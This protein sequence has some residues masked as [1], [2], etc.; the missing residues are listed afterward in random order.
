[1][2]Q[3]NKRIT[4]SFIFLSLLLIGVVYA[5]LQANLQINGVAKIQSNTWDIHFD[6]IQV[7]E[8]SVSIGTGD[9]AAT[10]DPENNCKVDFE[11]TLSLPGDFYEFTIDVVNAGTIDGM[12][13]TLQK[14]LIVNNEVVSE[15]PEYL[16]YTVTYSDGIEIEENHKLE[17]GTTESYLIRLEFSRNIEELP[18]AVTINTSLEPQY[19]QADSSAISKPIT[20]F[21]D[22]MS[23]NAKIKKLA[24]NSSARYSSSDSNILSFKKSEHEPNLNDMTNE[25]IVSTVDSCSPIY[26][27]YDNGIIYYY[28]DYNK[29]FLNADSSYMFHYLNNINLLELEEV[30]ASKVVSMAHMFD[31]TGF[32]I[33]GSFQIF[34]SNWNTSKVTDMNH[35]FYTAA[36]Q[37]SLINFDISNWDVSNV[38][39]MNSMFYYLGFI[40]SSVVWNIGDLSNWHTS[41]V[42]DMSYMFFRTA[43]GSQTWNIGDLSNW[44]VSSVTNMSNMFYQAGDHDASWSIGDLS[45]WDV[46]NVTNMSNMFC[47]SGSYVATNW[48]VGDLSDWDVSNVTDMSG[49]FH[50]TGSNNTINWSVGDLTSW[51]TSKVKNMKEMFCY[52]GRNATTW[53]SIGTLKVYATNIEKIF[54]NSY[55]AKATLKIYNNPTVYTNAFNYASISNGL[56]TVDYTNAV[57]NIDDIIA[58]K[59]SS[60]NVVKGSLFTP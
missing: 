43:V 40:K 22:G 14:T 37:A 5:I 32:S 4:S 24:G 52:A 55:K 45:N 31:F 12:V 50:G 41:N 27:W 47:S 59:T 11:V 23:F 19:I 15:V 46:S 20:S 34:F 16:I 26:A 51:D 2:Y 36:Y 29:P 54:D 21:I 33:N 18:S 28:S 56:I 44:D 1:M 58:T 13:G 25:N 8:N 60:S 49:M 3:R 42:T 6:N 10:I 48:S 38:T 39:D 30:D 57:T 35:M 7:N 53:Q 9:S 17:A